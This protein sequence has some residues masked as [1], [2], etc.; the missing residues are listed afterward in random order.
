MGGE[1]KEEMRG[2]AS[3]LTYIMILRDVLSSITEA[4]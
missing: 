2:L 3:I 4:V 1:D